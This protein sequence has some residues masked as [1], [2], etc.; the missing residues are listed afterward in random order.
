MGSYS[1]LSRSPHPEVATTL[2]KGKEELSYGKTITEL[3]RNLITTK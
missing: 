1:S 3:S 2:P